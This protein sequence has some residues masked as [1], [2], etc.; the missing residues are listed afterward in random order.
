M[1]GAKVR[2]SGGRKSP[3]GVQ[4]RSPGSGSGGRSPPEAEAF[5]LIY[6]VILDVLTMI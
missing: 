6:V 4:V 1:V 3:S 5:S 2:R